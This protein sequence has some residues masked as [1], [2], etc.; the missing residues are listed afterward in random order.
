MSTLLK[1]RP[2]RPATRSA[3]GVSLGRGRRPQARKLRD[4]KEALYHDHIV[5]VAEHIFAERGF[6]ETRMQ[7]IAAAAGV[8]LAKL[9]QFYPSKDK[10][11]RGVFLIRDRQMLDGFL[12]RW[13]HVV[14]SPQSIEQVLLLLETHLQFLL[15]HPDYLRLLLRE[16]Y[17]WYSRAAQPTSEEQRMW[18][19]GVANISMVLAWGIKEG[20][21]T[22]CDYREQAHMIMTVQQTRLANWVMGEMRQPHETVI[23]QIR[24]DF[25]RI[26]CRPEVAARLLSRDGSGLAAG[27]SERIAG[28]RQALQR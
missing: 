12:G 11:Y 18:D 15:N 23:A 16:G 21:F 17:A 19:R 13:G 3:D 26:C 10:L 14:Q 27:T 5:E 22:P 4:A 8:S 24:A 25:V 28:L 9:Y 1:S 2:A 20:F 6:N 7:D